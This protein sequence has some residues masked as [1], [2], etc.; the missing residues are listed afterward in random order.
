MQRH[1][2][3]RENECRGATREKKEAPPMFSAW[4]LVV[5]LP[6]SHG[7]T[8]SA[9]D[10]SEDLNLRSGGELPAGTEGGGTS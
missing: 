4:R 7:L 6:S 10:L 9:G 3:W 1:A 8:Y 2:P 5:R